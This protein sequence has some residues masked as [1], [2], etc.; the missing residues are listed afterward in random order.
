MQVVMTTYLHVCFAQKNKIKESKK[1]WE[2]RKAI[3]EINKNPLQSELWLIENNKKK[4]IE[5]ILKGKE[6]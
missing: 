2:I 4:I 5:N 3:D 6:E 1:N